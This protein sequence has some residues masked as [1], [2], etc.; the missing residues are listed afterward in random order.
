MSYTRESNLRSWGN[1]KVETLS[2][3][4]LI[5][6]GRT[7]GPGAIRTVF[8]TVLSQRNGIKMPVFRQEVRR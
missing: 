1:E 5:T 6:K 3:S 2:R 4:G 7:W 8:V